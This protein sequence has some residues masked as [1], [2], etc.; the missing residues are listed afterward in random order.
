MLRAAETMVYRLR[1]RLVER[2]LGCN[3]GIDC[4]KG[5]KTKPCS[6]A[7]ALSSSS[8]SALPTHLASWRVPFCSPLLRERAGW[9]PP[10]LLRAAAHGASC[11]LPL[12][13]ISPSPSTCRGCLFG[14]STPEAFHAS[15]RLNTHAHAQIWVRGGLGSH[16]DSSAAYCRAVGIS[17]PLVEP[18]AALWSDRG[19]EKLRKKAEREREDICC[20]QTI[21]R[22]RDQCSSCGELRTVARGGRCRHKDRGERGVS[23]L[24]EEEEQFVADVLEY[25]KQPETRPRVAAVLVEKGIQS[26][27]CF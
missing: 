16:T 22:H 7:L 17:Q 19:K 12:P 15:V 24:E 1:E 3:L 26:V 25:N 2:R 20:I 10:V 4:M 14:L 8:S 27:I 9:I 21:E 6:H 5:R 23:G 13:S 18:T 11:P